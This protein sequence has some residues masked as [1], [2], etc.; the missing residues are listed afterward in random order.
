[1]GVFVG[2]S[3]EQGRFVQVLAETRICSSTRHT[4]G[5]EKTT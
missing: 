3:D 5:P 1:V 4:G 2:R